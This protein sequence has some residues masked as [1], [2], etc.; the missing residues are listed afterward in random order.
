MTGKADA[1]YS[2][3]TRRVQPV[4][5]LSVYGCAA[6]V[7][8]RPAAPPLHLPCSPIAKL[9]EFG[10]KGAANA[11]AGPVRAENG[12][13]LDRDGRRNPHRLSHRCPRRR[14]TS[15]RAALRA[16]AP[17]TIRRSSSRCARKP[18]SWP[19]RAR[20][21]PT[22][23]TALPL[24]GI[25]VAVK[26]NIDV[27]GL[28]TTAACPA[29][30]YNP[31]RDATAVARLRAGR[32]A[33][34]RQDQSRPVRHRPR[35]RA[36]ALR[37]RP[38][39]VRRQGHPRRLVAPARRS[40]SAPASR[41]L[42]LGTDTAGSGRVPAMFTN[43]V[44]LKPTRGLISNAGVVPACR[45][46]DCVSIFALTADDAMTAL[47]VIAGP[48]PAD[49]FS[50][51]RPVHAVGAVPQG[52]RLGVPVAGGRLFFGDRLS[53]AAYEA[54]LARFAD[55]GATIVEIDIEPFYGAARL[56]YEGP[57]VAER[58][59]TVARA[60]RVLAGIAASGDAADRAR[61]RARLPRPTPSPHSISSRSCAAS[62]THLPLDRRAGAADG[63]DDLHRRAGA[64][65]P[66]RAQ[67]PGSAPTPISSICSISAASRCRPRC[68]PTASRSA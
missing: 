11:V 12:A 44:G 37:H 20:S 47:R 10:T 57:W 22:G 54:A 23:D 42:S 3:R 43:I 60:D 48:D 24:Y 35:R 18:R 68:A 6:P 17:M 33:H 53:Q 29:Y 58:Y 40:P 5:P 36:H 13:C 63:A 9:S 15:W 45:T 61:R 4:D 64:G 34:P 49:A 25:P 51:A 31:H 55:L 1:E 56:L 41:R 30:S 62:A 39:S 14:K 7:R 52:L 28:P 59:L 67:L 16:C 8:T 19:R 65:R 2:R 38:Q 26:D 21:P 66:D 46:L 50:R 32:R 27:K